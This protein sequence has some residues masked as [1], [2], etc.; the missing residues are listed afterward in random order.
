[1]PLVF[2]GMMDSVIS[3]TM[4][5]IPILFFSEYCIALSKKQQKPERKKRK[6]SDF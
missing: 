2:P 4:L 6:T 3:G 1:M 5:L